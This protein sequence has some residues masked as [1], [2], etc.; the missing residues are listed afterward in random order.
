MANIVATAIATDWQTVEL[1][2]PAAE[3]KFPALTPEDLCLIAVPSFSGRVPSY[4]AQMLQCL[5][6][7]TCKT[8]LLCVYGNRD[9]EDVLVELEDILKPKGFRI[10][11]ALTAIAQHSV[12]PYA[13][14]RPDET[15]IAQLQQAAAQIKAK[16]ASG[17]VTAPTLPGNR[18]YRTVSKIP[19]RPY[20]DENC[21]ECGIC[22]T[23]CPVGA[24]FFED[25]KHCD[26][27]LCIRCMKCVAVCPTHARTLPP[28]IVAT[29][30][31]KMKALF[32]VRKEPQLFI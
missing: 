1:C 4:A 14:G 7:L 6:N 27:E 18:P 13:A 25:V 3:I 28:A 8:I 17:A 19:M 22:A 20:G 2:R 10:I 26:D 16:L 24:I 9:Y 15:D 31:E 32:A 21:L 12:M 23:A 5:P 29:V 11:A 30:A